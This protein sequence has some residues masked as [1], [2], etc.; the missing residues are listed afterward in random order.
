[1]TK[2][3][4]LIFSLN[5]LGMGQPLMAYNVEQCEKMA[6]IALFIHR[7]EHPHMPW[8]HKCVEVE[9]ESGEAT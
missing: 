7:K 2:V 3:I 6:E 1:M 8:Q 9:D 4:L 5:P